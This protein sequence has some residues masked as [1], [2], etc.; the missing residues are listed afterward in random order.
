[1]GG[2]DI[3]SARWDVPPTT[4]ELYEHVVV[5]AYELE[6]PFV[7]ESENTIHPTIANEVRL[8][9]EQLQVVFS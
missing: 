7:G 5:D 8:L 9:Q 6:V 4:S 2:G 1:M 3:L